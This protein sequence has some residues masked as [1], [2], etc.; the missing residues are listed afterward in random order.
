[1]ELLSC[2]VVI[3]E[4]GSVAEQFELSDV[5]V[6]LKVVAVVLVI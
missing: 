1:V 6:E 3:V 2:I 4:S 5:S